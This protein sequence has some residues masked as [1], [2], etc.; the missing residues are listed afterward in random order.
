MMEDLARC[1]SA[2]VVGSSGR[3][4]E[5]YFGISAEIQGS[6]FGRNTFCLVEPFL[7]FCRNAILLQKLILSAEIRDFCRHFGELS[8]NIIIRNLAERMYFCRKLSFQQK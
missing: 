3:P 8:A 5:R 1:Q 2:Y 7:S 6:N 4:K